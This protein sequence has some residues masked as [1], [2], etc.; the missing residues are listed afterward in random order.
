MKPAISRIDGPKLSSSVRTGLGAWSIGFAL[1]TTLFCSSSVS[2]PGSAN[3]GMTVW[4]CAEVLALDDPSS[5]Y[6]TAGLERALDDVAAAGDLDH[7]A[8]GYLLAEERVRHVDALRPR[9]G[10]E[11]RDEQVVEGQDD[12]ED[13]PPGPRPELEPTLLGGRLRWRLRPRRPRPVIRATVGRR[14]RGRRAAGS[15]RR[16]RAAHRRIAFRRIMPSA[17]PADRNSPPRR[18]QSGR[19]RLVR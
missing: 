10:H 11:D 2:S 15:P 17:M 14:G 19:G 4:N 8:R 9:R 1:T 3:D 7:V 5:G 13:Q 6:V 18:S 12:Q 16:G